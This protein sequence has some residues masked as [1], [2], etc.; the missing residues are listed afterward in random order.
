[1]Q[2]FVFRGVLEYH[3][4]GLRHVLFKT[5]TPIDDER[6]LFCQ[7]VARNDNPDTERIDGIVALD[8]M[9]QA[10]D[11]VLLEAIA[12]D[13]PLDVHSEL[14]TKADRMTLEYRRALAELAPDTAT[15][16]LARV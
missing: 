4:T 16:G 1:V 12:A 11:K 9:V 8:R 14:H 2:P 10:E 5:A 15:K 13:F 3:E 6:T 7:F